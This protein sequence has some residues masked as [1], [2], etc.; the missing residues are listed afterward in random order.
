M[1]NKQ[2]AFEI[3]QYE[4]EIETITGLYIGAGKTGMRIGGVDNEF[5]RN[6][7]TDEPYIPGS[8]LKG[9]VRSLLEYYVGLLAVSSNGN[10]LSVADIPK[11]E[12][13]KD[14]CNKK[15]ME[16]I[17][18]LFGT[19]AS[20]NKQDS[21]EDITNQVD[22][23]YG[24]TRLSFS[25]LYLSKDSNDISNNKKTNDYD[26]TNV[27]EVKPETTINRLTGKAENPRFTERVVAGTKF[28]GFI[29]LKLLHTYKDKEDSFLNLL[30]IGLKLLELDALGGSS[31]R[32][33]GKVSITFNGEKL[34]SLED[35][36]KSKEQ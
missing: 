23:N 32:G 36:E 13:S 8:S 35:L 17:L 9:K 24:I 2:K 30:K 12:S 29:T 3:K 15:D 18:K 14:L 19:A 7:A 16:N 5:I 28:K 4:I 31:S 20:N 6:P 33:Y 27:F 1:A 25:D 10:V 26:F 22:K 34:S 21:K 11:D